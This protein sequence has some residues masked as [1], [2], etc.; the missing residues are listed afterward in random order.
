MVF[1][2]TKD[3]EPDIEFNTQEQTVNFCLKVDKDIWISIEFIIFEEDYSDSV[4]FKEI[5]GRLIL[6]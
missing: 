6:E 5:L 2:I 4:T 3:M 1:K